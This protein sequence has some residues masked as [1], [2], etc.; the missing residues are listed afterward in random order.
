MPDPVPFTKSIRFLIEH[1][2][3]TPPF[4]SG[5]FYYSVAYWYQTEPHAPFPKLPTAAE[6]MSWAR[7]NLPGFIRDW[8]AIGPF[9]NKGRK[10]F[11]TVYPPERKID[12]EEA[13][14][15]VGGQARWKK[16][17]ADAAGCL[18]FDGHF[19]PNDDVAGYA[20][21][22]VH[23]PKRQP[24]LLLTGSDDTIT[25]WLNGKKI[26]AKEPYRW[27]SPDQDET[28]I[29]L[30][31]GWNTL[32]IKVCEGPHRWDLYCRIVAPDRALLPGLRYA[33]DR[34]RP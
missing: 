15:G 8:W 27:A 23:S 14:P 11:A 17:K 21:A 28:K 30:K 12:L 7:P 32:L 1:G 34:Q 2:R 6:R 9:D 33:L 5:N 22:Y 3:G 25:A 24:A 29:A 18:N 26:L 20:L 4:R 13:Y 16:A 19:T 31:A 10:G